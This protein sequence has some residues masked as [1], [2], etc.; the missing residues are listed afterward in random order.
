MLG[1]FTAL[2]NADVATVAQ[3]GRAVG[4]ADELG[5]AVGNDQHR[6][7]GIAELA[8]L[9]EEP[10]GGIEVERSGGLVEN[11]DPRIAQK[12]A[13]DG[14]PLLEAKRQRSRKRPDVDRRAD[15]IVHERLRGAHLGRARHGGGEEAVGAHEQVVDDRA[16]VGDEHFLEHGRDADIARLVRGER[17][18]AEDGHAAAVGRQH[19]R[20]HL[21]ERALA[22]A[23]AA[24]DGVDLAEVRREIAAVQRARWAK[25]FLEPGHADAHGAH[26]VR[27]HFG[28]CVSLRHAAELRQEN[29]DCRRKLI[30]AGRLRLGHR[31]PGGLRRPGAD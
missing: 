28:W 3:H 29:R 22:A 17:G 13:A 18:A 10:F 14:D 5:D 1:D 4:D 6:R 27:R 2:E 31:A 11:E 23:I 9:R 26:G 7:S 20:Y 12:G 21:G 16:F 30:A 24:H 19:A 8:H 25:E 15:E